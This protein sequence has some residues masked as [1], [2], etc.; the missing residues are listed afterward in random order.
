[1]EFVV[2]LTRLRAGSIFRHRAAVAVQKLL[3]LGSRPLQPCLRS[4][5]PGL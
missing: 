5:Q 1:M 2:L 4:C 3:H